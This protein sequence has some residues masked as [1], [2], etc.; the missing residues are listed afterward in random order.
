MLATAGPAGGGAAEERG[1]AYIGELRKLGD[2]RRHPE[3]LTY[4]GSEIRTGCAGEY[5]RIAHGLSE[6]KERTES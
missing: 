1:A 3:V 4:L 5:Y 2:A 6:W